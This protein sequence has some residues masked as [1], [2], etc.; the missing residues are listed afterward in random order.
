MIIIEFDKTLSKFKALK[1]CLDSVQTTYQQN[2]DKIVIEANIPDGLHDLSVELIESGDRLEIVDVVV[3]ECGSRQNLYFSYTCSDDTIIQPSTAL[4]ETGQ[5]WHYPFALPLSHWHKLMTQK[6]PG[7]VLGQDLHSLFQIYWPENIDPG[8]AFPRLVRD[9]F[10]RSFDFTVI[11]KKDHSR[12]RVP[13]Q[14]LQ[15][16]SVPHTIT[17]ELLE[18]CDKLRSLSVVGGQQIYNLKDQPDL[19]TT[20]TWGVTYFTKDRK[21][22]PE[23]K[24]VFPQTIAWLESLDLDLEVVYVGILEPGHYISPHCDF[25][26]QL[27]PKY[28]GC[29]QLYIPINWQPGC[30]FKFADVGLLPVQPCVINNTRYVHSLINAS[31]DIRLSLAAWCDVVALKGRWGLTLTD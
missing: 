26:Y 8:T 1:I 24:T 3:D 13:Y 21:W 23:V 7:D 11:S 4:W 14:I 9:H 12:F 10:S 28:E 29:S 6:F 2:V 31:T 19:D 30:Y 20:K 27:D 17:H 15:N 5:I 25:R 16:F 18:Q 22:R